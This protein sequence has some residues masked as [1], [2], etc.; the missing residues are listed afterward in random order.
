[1]N[2]S[3][4]AHTEAVQSRIDSVTELK[5]V[6]SITTQLFDLSKE[7][8]QLEYETF[9]LK[10]KAALASEIKSTLDSWVRFETQQR[11]SEQLDLVK[12]VQEKVLAS[13]RDSK[14]QKEILNQAVADLDGQ[15]NTLFT[16]SLDTSY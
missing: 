10:Q 7:T 12:S 1:M 11:E 15:F 9:T 2:A 3:R 13:L 16:S 6:E 4:S 8:A 5:D 14:N